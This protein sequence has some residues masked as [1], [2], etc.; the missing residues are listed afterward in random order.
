M[1]HVTVVNIQIKDLAALAL[2][3]QRL[4][5]SLNLNQRNYKWY[6][7]FVGDYREAGVNPAEMGECD[8]AIKVVGNPDAY[9]IGIAAK[10]GAP[11]IFE[12]R[13]DFYGGGN[14]LETV[15]G[16][17]CNRLVEEYTKI[18]AMKEAIKIAEAK[19]Y[20]VSSYLDRATGD[21]V[22]VLS[23]QTGDHRIVL[24]KPAVVQR[25]VARKVAP[26]ASV[27]VPKA[28]QTTTTPIVAAQPTSPEETIET[29]KLKV[30]GV[31]GESCKELTKLLEEAMGLTQHSENTED[32]YLQETNENQ[33][34]ETA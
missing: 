2:A 3:C 26:Q 1:S 25:P 20:Q 17:R 16:K 6:G 18:V 32:Y 31:K 24:S 23:G 33:A 9:E 7:I 29:I 22:I 27:A 8:H 30:E 13:Y 34:E 28:I 14:G 12:L 11:G 19:G 21:T 5:L 15:V 10:N 4:G